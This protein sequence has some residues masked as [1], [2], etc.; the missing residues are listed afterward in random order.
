LQK[1]AFGFCV[2]LLGAK[3]IRGAKVGGFAAVAELDAE[4]QV[5][6]WQLLAR[7]ASATE[8]VM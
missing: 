3:P 7:D 6:V 4:S 8:V 1:R 5:L 2:G